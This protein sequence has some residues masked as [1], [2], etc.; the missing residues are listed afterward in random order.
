MESEA[1]DAYDIERECAEEACYL[2][3]DG[4]VRK[5]PN[6]QEAEVRAAGYGALT[7][8]VA[9]LQGSAFALLDQMFAL[10]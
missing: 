8:V 10:T 1:Y 2:G 3:V 6:A 4:F 5:Y 7:A 9:Y